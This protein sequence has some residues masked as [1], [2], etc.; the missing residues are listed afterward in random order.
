MTGSLEGVSGKIIR[1]KEDGSGWPVLPQ[2]REENDDERE[3]EEKEALED[4]VDGRCFS[5]T[6]LFGF[7][8]CNHKAPQAQ[9]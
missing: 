1:S 6:Y 7:F 4:S 2:S 9:P 3:E 8:S 5:S